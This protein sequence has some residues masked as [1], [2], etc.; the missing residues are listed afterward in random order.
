MFRYIERFSPLAFSKTLDSEEGLPE[1]NLLAIVD[2]IEVADKLDNL[3]K[4]QLSF[5]LRDYNM[6][7]L[8]I[9]QRLN[10]RN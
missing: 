8:S 1:A 9:G 7:M 4:S 2:G 5:Y 6:G 10:R 3:V